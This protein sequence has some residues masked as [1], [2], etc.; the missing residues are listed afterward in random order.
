MF[1]KRSSQA[2]L[3]FSL[4]LSLLNS[5]IFITAS[6][7]LL[8][9]AYYLIDSAIVGKEREV[10]QARI[11]E[12][13]AWYSEGGLKALK[14]RFRES[15]VKSRDIF[16]LRILG[17]AGGVVFVNLPKDASKVDAARLEASELSRPDFWLSIKGQDHKSTWTVGS[18][19]LP[20]GLIMQVGKNSTQSHQLRRRLRGV[21]IWFVIPAL[22]LGLLGGVLVTYRAIR[23]I[24]R[25]SETVEH[26]L[27][28]GSLDRRVIR[29][30]G[31]SEL[32]ELVQLF[33]RMLDQNQALINGMR[34]SLD[35]VAHDLRT[36]MTR[37][38]GSAE[39][40]LGQPDDPTGLR[41]ALAD[42]MEES[43]QVLTML[44][45]LMDVAEAETGA[46][47]LQ[48]EEVDLA[49]VV[50]SVLDLYGLLA[51]E[52]GVELKARVPGE[53]VVK[54]DRARLKQVLAN[55]L[56]NALKYIGQGN[57]VEV[58]AEK[59]QSA[60]LIRV[61]DN[62]LGIEPAEQDK[63]WQRL[64]RGDQSRSKRG[65]GLGLSLVKAMVNAHGGTIEVESR[66]GRGSCFTISLPS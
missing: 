27:R 56:D 41:E 58:S 11:Q 47:R 9:A 14:E 45:T 7:V 16:F 24:R 49:P 19:R 34:E 35:N 63:I 22:G 50:D 17:P 44:N 20:G 33:N 25:L 39:M 4:Q 23:P 15:S 65:L 6:L 54:A 62:G 52:A 51:E 26:I 8:F 18:A 29:G 1:S 43:E 38:R 3:T 21:F 32:D 57:L 30:K 60:V 46:M 12:Y 31:Q 36:P 53:L 55:L 13:R 59:D 64:Y 42:C 28:T 5:L 66:P 10:V 61:R 48:L 37:L 2:G 40:A